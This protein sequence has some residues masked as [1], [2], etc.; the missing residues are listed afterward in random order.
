[1]ANGKYI[2]INYP[3]KDSKKGFFLDLNDEDNQAIKA[4]LLHLILTRKG[5][6]L[7][8][9]DFGTDLIK[10]IFEPEDGMTLNDIK[11]E[12]TTT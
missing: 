3:F 12:I 5:Q 4:D 10:F 7:Y 1:M 8:N 9:P 6:R 2:N 11:S